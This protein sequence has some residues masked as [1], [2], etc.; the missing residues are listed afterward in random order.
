MAFSTIIAIERQMRLSNFY[1]FRILDKQTKEVINSSEV[2]LPVDEAISLLHSYLE[3]LQDDW[4]YITVGKIFEK[5]TKTENDKGFI[6]STNY[7]YQYRLREN[8]ATKAA[9]GGSLGGDT[10]QMILA[11]QAQISELSKTIA[12]DN[13]R[14]EMD[15]KINKLQEKNKQEP[16][17]LDE[18][19]NKILLTFERAKSIG[20]DAAP[21]SI[22]ANHSAPA[23]VTK[24]DASDKEK[25]Q[26]AL[27]ILGTNGVTPDV[28]YK[29]ALYSNQ[30]KD[31]FN[32]LMEQLTNA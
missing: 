19:F 10:F 7:T 24:L 20:A 27:K 11:Q 4:V 2:L 15:E 32:M 22:A 5:K 13:L 28:L 25:M 21:A 1:A 26:Q 9:G 14:R 29:L 30:H 17:S 16:V 23:L 8:A 3:E 12:L 6:Y 31:T 18:V